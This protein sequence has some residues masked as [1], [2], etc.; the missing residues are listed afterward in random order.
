MVGVLA[1]HN[2]PLFRNFQMIVDQNLISQQIMSSAI[3]KSK[4]KRVGRPSYLSCNEEALIFVVSGMKGECS[5]PSMQKGIS[6]TLN[7]II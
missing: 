6:D 5:L 2:V 4:I 3:E 1:P 7:S